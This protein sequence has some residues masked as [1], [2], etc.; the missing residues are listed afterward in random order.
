MLS[1][2]KT[3][4]WPELRWFTGWRDGSS[5]QRPFCARASTSV[6]GAPAPSSPTRSQEP[7]LY[8][9]RE[10]CAPDCVATALLTTRQPCVPRSET[11]L[12]PVGVAAAAAGEAVVVVAAAGPAGAT[13]L[14]CAPAARLTTDVATRAKQVP[15]ARR[16]R[17]IRF[18]VGNS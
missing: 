12:A 3:L 5:G 15:R 11:S 9:G 13:G 14:A 2:K 10:I 16:G 18:T 6:P 8:P 7:A 1:A 4:C 17:A